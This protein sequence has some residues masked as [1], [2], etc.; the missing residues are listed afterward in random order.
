MEKFSVYKNV[1]KKKLALDKLLE[2]ACI[3]L[4]STVLMGYGFN[5][6]FIKAREGV[7]RRMA[8]RRRKRK[9][10]SPRANAR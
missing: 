6:A 9:R 1:L 2:D 4:A 8:D 7:L 10:L 5:S 3:L